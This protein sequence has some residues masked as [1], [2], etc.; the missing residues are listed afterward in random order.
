[1]YSIIQFF[2]LQESFNKSFIYFLFI[3]YPSKSFR[4]A[5]GQFAVRN[6]LY[7]PKFQ[8]K[9]YFNYFEGLN[10]FTSEKRLK[11]SYK[12]SINLEDLDFDFVLAHFKLCLSVNEGDEETN[13]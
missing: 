2:L 1:M 11:I 4:H 13:S 10:L 9:S 7:G 8:R 6:L 5:I 3:S 12:T